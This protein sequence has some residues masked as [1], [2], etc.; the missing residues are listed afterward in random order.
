VPAGQCCTKGEIAVVFR[1][2]VA[3]YQQVDVPEPYIAHCDGVCSR[4]WVQ[5]LS[6]FAANSPNRAGVLANRKV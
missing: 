3:V 2:Y 6:E 4:F 1:R 5:K